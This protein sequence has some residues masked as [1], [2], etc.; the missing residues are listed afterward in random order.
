MKLTFAALIGTFL[1]FAYAGVQPVT[2]VKDAAFSFTTSFLKD[3]PER[4]KQITYSP[5]PVPSIS[6]MPDSKGATSAPA[7]DTGGIDSRTGVY[8][9][10]YLGLVEEPEGT[11]CDSYG[12]FVVLIN[13]RNAANPNYAQL[14][15]FLKTD[16]TDSFPYV[17]ALPNLLPYY[18]SA[19]SHVDLASVKAIIEGTVGPNPPR[20]CV[21]F[22]ENLH[23]S[24]EM[25]GIRCGFVSIDLSGSSSGHALNV[26]ETTDRGL[27]YVDDTGVS[28]PGPSSCDKTVD[29]KL[30][31]EYIP[32]SLFPE[33]GWASA[34]DNMGAVTGIY[35]TWDGNWNN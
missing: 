1:I 34:W 10:F 32:K 8:G 27:V 14:I 21:D 31:R 26:F 28:N 22:A 17:Y 18:G 3:L 30:G 25:A 9:S 11:D 7:S 4:V 12:D 15:A 5:G 24:A 35:T 6:G 29:L 19:E 2:A 33:V 13:N 16:A 23:N 20:I